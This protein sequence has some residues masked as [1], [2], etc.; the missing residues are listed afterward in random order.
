VE[1][2]GSRPQHELPH[3]YEWG[4]VFALPTIEDGFAVVLC[5][6]LAAGLPLLTTTNCAGPDLVFEGQNGWIIP[7]RSPEAL[8]SRLLWLE[9]HRIELVKAIHC[10]HSTL[11][12]LDWS[13]TG[14]Q[15]ERNIFQGLRNK[16]SR[17][18]A[19][20]KPTIP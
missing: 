9:T 3:E 19:R 4:D 2:L 15:A 5:Q 12:D 7:I 20:L 6:A 10:A 11:R 14:L 18:M 16:H 17:P 8:L 13:Q 1:F